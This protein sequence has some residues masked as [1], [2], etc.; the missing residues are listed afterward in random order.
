[1][2]KKTFNIAVGKAL[3]TKRTELGGATAG[4]N[5]S[6]TV[7]YLAD[8]LGYKSDRSIYLI[9]TGAYTVPFTDFVLY[10]EAMGMSK[11]ETVEFFSQIVF[12]NLKK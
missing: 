12:K 7:R 6:G 9:E 1:M 2:D 8:K 4:R 10:C 3:R 11:E 5:S